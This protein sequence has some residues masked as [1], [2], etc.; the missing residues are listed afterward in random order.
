MRA[1]TGLMKTW[2]CYIKVVSQK[3]F[4]V[5]L[6]CWLVMPRE[7]RPAHAQSY[8]PS[9]EL[10]DVRGLRTQIKKLTEKA[11][12][13]EAVS[14]AK[15]VL[16]L[17]SNLLPPN[18]PDIAESLNDLGSVYTEQ[19][20][21]D[22]ALALH[23]QAYTIQKKAFDQENEAIATSLS[24]IGAAQ[25]YKGYYTKALG[26]HRRALAIRETVLG[27]DSQDVAESLINVA[28]SHSRLGQFDEAQSQGKRALAI[29]E[30]DGKEKRLV[31]IVLSLL[32]QVCLALGDIEEAI[33]LVK[34]ALSVTIETLGEN[35]PSTALR[36]SSLATLYM[37]QGEYSKS[38]DHYQRALAI[39][40]RHPNGKPHY[41]ADLLGNIASLYIAKGEYERAIAFIKRSEPILR[42]AL[43]GDHP[44]LSR[45]PTLLALIHQKRGQYEQS[46]SLLNETL[47]IQEKRLPR[48]HPEVART[49]NNLVAV[50]FAQGRTTEALKNLQ[51]SLAIN[52]QTIGEDHPNIAQ[53][54]SSLAT[55]Y[56]DDERPEKCLPVLHRVLKIQEKTL[57]DGH[58]DTINT[59]SSL[60]LVY[61]SV[62]DTE[63]AERY[64][65]RAENLREE[66]FKLVFSADSQQARR[67]YLNKV[68]SEIHTTISLSVKRE[69]SPMMRRAAFDT[70]LHRKGRVIDSTSSTLD[71]VR[72]QATSQTIELL[73][74]YRR[75]RMRKLHLLLT[76]GHNSH[77]AQITDLDYRA[78][79]LERLIRKDS[80]LFKYKNN[81]IDIQ[82][83]QDILP[84]DA[85]LIEWV[86][87]REYHPQGKTPTERAGDWHYA[88]AILFKSG[89]PIW[90]ELG[91]ADV[92]D[93]EIQAFREALFRRSSAMLER[94]RT[95]DMRVMSKVRGRLGNINRLFLAPDSKLN[96]VPFAALVDE[97]GRYLLEEYY[98]SYLTS[99]RELVRPVT[100]TPARQPP[101]IVGAPDAGPD[102]SNTALECLSRISRENHTLSLSMGREINLVS[103]LLDDVSVRQGRDATEFNLKDVHGPAIFHIA[104]HGFF[105]RDVKGQTHSLPIIEDPRAWLIMKNSLSQEL[106]ITAEQVRDAEVSMACSGLILGSSERESSA[107]LNDAYPVDEADEAFH[108]DGLLTATE[109]AHFDL[110]GTQLAVLS[111][112]ETGLGD[113]PPHPDS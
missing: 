21:F 6:I 91:D 2:Q 90:V 61:W 63:S 82:S 22:D 88:A 29:L 92:I 43:G 113:T 20:Q 25:Y 36:L 77:K 79:N 101:L 107:K 28:A 14:I 89:D 41:L 32:G 56:L 93:T 45:I 94:A 34:R 16:K 105:F 23:Y 74:E 112:C 78:E 4:L 46:I 111:A 62:G 49:L 42:K 85:A 50:Q 103:K 26:N 15:R 51:E 19:G 87:Y 70:L 5:T 98:I 18:H 52:E 48:V 83:V 97:N 75:N 33:S 73:E 55:Y 9:K 27:K 30:H 58:P 54:L 59:L 17:R 7:F 99:G 86:R 65:V 84:E 10:N 67:S 3:L 68:S 66:Y 100:D 13:D 64:F 35:H 102:T 95:L 8:D 31:A 47:R 72:S 108:D 81:S 11:K 57:G 69:T 106:D 109:L 71:K 60:A 44:A 1:Y 12:Y 110:H 24:E 76:G 80:K 37:Y 38:L 40:N 39:M 53:S 104:A 96:L